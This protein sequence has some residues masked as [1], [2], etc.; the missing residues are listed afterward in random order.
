MGN[1]GGKCAC[2]D[3]DI[4]RHLEGALIHY[5]RGI[6]K[7][8][9]TFAEAAVEYKNVNPK[10]SQHYSDLVNSQNAFIERVENSKKVIK[11]LPTCE[12]NGGH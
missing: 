4:K 1:N 3:E 2:L 6:Q 11:E 9:A 8:V 5:I 12:E 7:D 10:L